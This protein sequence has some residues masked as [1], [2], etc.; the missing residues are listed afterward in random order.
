MKTRP[1]SKADPIEREI[2]RALHPGAFIR[3]RECYSFVSELEK[4]AVTVEWMIA[5]DPARAV[6]LYE[7]FLAG[8][9]AKADELDDSSGSFGQFAQDIICGWIKARQASG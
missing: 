6:E 3:D 7:T 1:R 2:E 8:C 9:H 5:T 4:L